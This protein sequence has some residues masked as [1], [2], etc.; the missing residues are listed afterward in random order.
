MGGSILDF[1]L[2]AGLV[3]KSVILILLLFSIFSWAVIIYKW[4]F[5]ARAKRENESFLK[6]FNREKNSRT[7]Y[8]ASRGMLVSPLAAIFRSVYTEENID[9][10]EL[11]RSIKRY[12]ALEEAKL[13]RYL[14]FLATTGSTT[15][16]I[17]LFGTVW[18]IMNAFRGIGAAGSA[19][20]AV[21][22]P[23]IAE[24]LITTAFGLATAIPAVIGYNYYLSMARRMIIAMEDFAEELEDYFSRP[25]T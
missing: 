18:G 8:L 23:G 13:L 11:R 19:A 20:L 17:G 24:A 4:R 25:S 10:V 14:N 1:I 7:L 15:P 6:L 5:F 3:V 16:F 21:V 12:M 9:R 2:Q 22:A